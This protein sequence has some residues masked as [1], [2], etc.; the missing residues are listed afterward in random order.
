MAIDLFIYIQ[1]AL[2]ERT[3]DGVTEYAYVFAGTNSVED[4]IENYH[5]LKKVLS[6]SNN[7]V[8]RMV[9]D[10]SPQICIDG[11]HIYGKW[12]VAEVMKKGRQLI[13]AAGVHIKPEKEILYVERMSDSG[14]YQCCCRK[15]SASMAARQP[16]AAAFT[17]C[18]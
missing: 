3:I 6:D 4:F 5:S 14:I 10:I 7:N 12:S 8:H 13:E 15:R 1:S 9:S 2:F 11:I 16:E 17:A 18:M